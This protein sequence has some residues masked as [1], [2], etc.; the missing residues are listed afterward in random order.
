MNGRTVISWRD[1]IFLLVAAVFL[2]GC[3]ASSHRSGKTLDPGQFS[4]GVAYDGLLDMEESE[5]DMAHLFALDGRVGVVGGLDIGAAHTWDLT[6]DNE[7]AFATW[8]GD[9]KVQLNNRENFPGIPILSL[10]VIKGYAYHEDAQTH[11]TSFPVTVSVPTSETS[12]QYFI[13]RFENFTE[14][15]IP[16]E[17]EDPRHGFFLGSEFQLG[18]SG[19]FDPVLGVDVGLLTSL[20][21]GEGD[22]MLVLNAGV[23]FNSPSN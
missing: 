19:S 9:A 5:T 3:V 10:G 7:G 12:T 16:D 6:A 13:Y 4:I 17:W 14:D 15:F 20:Y 22:M 11:V 2:F 23:S 1:Y 8:W 21:G 18:E